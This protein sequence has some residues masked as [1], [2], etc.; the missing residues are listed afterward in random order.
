VNKVLVED[1]N[2]LKELKLKEREKSKKKKKII[3]CIKNK[4]EKM[5]LAIK[6]SLIKETR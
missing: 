6:E 5:K 3:S 4:V 2:P 1:K